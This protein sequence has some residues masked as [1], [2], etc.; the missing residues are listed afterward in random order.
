MKDEKE[1]FQ[2]NAIKKP[3]NLK[4]GQHIIG[5]GGTRWAETH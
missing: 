3:L 1:E 4:V 5:S 2:M